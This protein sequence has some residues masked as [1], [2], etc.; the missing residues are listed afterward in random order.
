[1][2]TLFVVI[3]SHNIA[4]DYNMSQIFQI[5]TPYLSLDE[6]AKRTGQSLGSVV[7]QANRG[8]LPVEN[9]TE[10]NKRGKRFVNMIALFKQANKYPEFKND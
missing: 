3:K 10:E 6:Y 5:D 4:A 9:F 7:N 2:M 8:Q 1:M